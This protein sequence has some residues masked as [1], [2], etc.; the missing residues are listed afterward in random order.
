MN[1]RVCSFLVHFLAAVCLDTINKVLI[2]IVRACV[3]QFQ[4]ANQ[5]QKYTNEQTNKTWLCSV[6]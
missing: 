2:C 4:E 3:D 1:H 5:K 6:R